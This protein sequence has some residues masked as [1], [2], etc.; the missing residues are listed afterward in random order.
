[1]L[2][3]AEIES[4]RDGLRATQRR[5]LQAFCD[6]GS[7]TQACNDAGISRQ[8]P[9]DWLWAEGFHSTEVDDAPAG[10]FAYALLQAK[11]MVAED[12][13]GEV[14]RQALSSSQGMP[15]AIQRI[16]IT[17]RWMPEYRDQLN[18]RHSGAVLQARV[19]VNHLN[20]D[21]RVELLGLIQRRLAGAP[22]APA[23]DPPP[24]DEL[25]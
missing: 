16:F 20:P 4:G 15:A 5:F 21:E 22:Q 2:T 13:L 1:M 10:T 14:H 24:Q 8:A 9:Y 11:R 19:D 7:I 17:K 3:A 6:S 25:E 12:V 23:G 18:V